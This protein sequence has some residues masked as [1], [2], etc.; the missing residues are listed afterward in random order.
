MLV[1]IPKIQALP[2]HILQLEITLYETNPSANH[3]RRV[4]QWAPSTPYLRYLLYPH[5]LLPKTILSPPILHEGHFLQYPINLIACRR[6]PELLEKT[7]SQ[8]EY[9]N[10]TFQSE[11]NPF[12]F[13]AIAD[14]TI[15][16]VT[17]MLPPVTTCG[18]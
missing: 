7:Q 15:C 10:S 18:N 17:M 16:S 6:Y 4:Q 12:V 11:L 9:A 13:L 1:L 3:M 8:V 5:Q 2:D 14:S